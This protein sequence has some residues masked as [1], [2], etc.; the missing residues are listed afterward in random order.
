MGSR[1]FEFV[2]LEGVA[3]V[4][5]RCTKRDG[6][7]RARQICAALYRGGWRGGY[8]PTFGQVARFHGNA[9]LLRGICTNRSSLTDVKPWN[10][11]RVG[12]VRV[13]IIR[14]SADCRFWNAIRHAFFFLE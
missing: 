14:V 2:Y 8:L 7:A 10:F 6:V 13:F 4:L 11:P 5:Q 12:C 3:S 9:S 1:L